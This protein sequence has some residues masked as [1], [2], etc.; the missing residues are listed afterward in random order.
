MA[1]HRETMVRMG[2]LAATRSADEVLVSLGL[3]SCIGVAVIDP[4]SRVAGL[5]HIM[6]PAAT[7]GAASPGARSADEGVPA[8]V[9]AVVELGAR[10]SRLEATLVG[11]AAMFSGLDIGARN[12]EAVHAALAA[13]RIPVRAA[14]TGGSTGRTIRIYVSVARVT[15]T[16]AGGRETD[17]G[18]GRSLPKLGA[19]A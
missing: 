14:A 2:E 4:H 10:R 15:V 18:P 11:G 1:G 5:A 8:L 13:E 3:G 17:L 6:L 19:L 7:P 9:D 12:A 16:E